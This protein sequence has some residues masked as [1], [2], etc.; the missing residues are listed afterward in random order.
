MMKTRLAIAAY[1]SLSTFLAWS[2][3]EKITR[4]RVKK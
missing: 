2:V 4:P 1:C 3:N